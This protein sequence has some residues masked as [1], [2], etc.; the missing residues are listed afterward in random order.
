MYILLSKNQSTGISLC[1]Q[2]KGNWFSHAENV[3]E[4]NF[5]VRKT[6]FKAESS[7]TGKLFPGL[8]MYM[9]PVPGPNKTTQ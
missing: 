2:Q 6:F 7:Q 5:F 4:A 1:V 3:F 8:S 9:Y